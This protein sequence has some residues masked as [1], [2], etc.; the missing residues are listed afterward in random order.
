VGLYKDAKTK[1]DQ[2]ALLRNHNYTITITKVNDYGFEKLDDAVKSDPENRLE[3]NVVD[4]NPAITNMIACKDYELGVSDNLSLK[5]TDTKAR[6][7]LVTT[8]KSGTYNV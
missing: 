6:I 8:L 3:V 1:K 7:T 2:Y 5:A 4:D